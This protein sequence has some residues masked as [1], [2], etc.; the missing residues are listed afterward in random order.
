[1]SPGTEQG[2]VLEGGVWRA[3]PGRGQLLAVKQHLL[4]KELHKLESLG[5][6]AWV[7]T[8]PS[9]IVEWRTSGGV[10]IK[11]PRQ[12]DSLPTTPAPASTPF[13]PLP[14]AFPTAL[15]LHLFPTIRIT[16]NCDI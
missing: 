16:L 10:T 15:I 2:W 7:T 11:N 8:G 1:M 9:A 5:E 14:L 6:E 4:V 3:D 13:L 12:G